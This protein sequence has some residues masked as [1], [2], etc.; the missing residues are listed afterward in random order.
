MKRLEVARLTDPKFLVLRPI[1]K[2]L[3]DAFPPSSVFPDGLDGM[4]EDLIALLRAPT[5]VCLIGLEDDVPLGL[6]IILLPTNKVAPYPQILHFYNGGSLQ[7]R[8]I[9]TKTTVEVLRRM[10]Y[11]KFWA[12]NATRKPDSVWA[13]MFRLAGPARPVGGVMEFDIS[14]ET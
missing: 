9:L 7:L 10:G 2:L 3:H 12:L 11:I 6:S 1:Q 8:Q 13:R 5:T 4:L 14:K